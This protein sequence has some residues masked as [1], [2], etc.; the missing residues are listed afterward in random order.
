[1]VTE[2]GS[3]KLKTIH[4]YDAPVDLIN[5]LEIPMPDGADV[6]CVQ[7]QRDE[8]RIWAHIDLSRR[9]DVMRRFRWVGTGWN[10][11]VGRYVG[12]VQQAG[13]VWHLFEVTA[14]EG[15]DR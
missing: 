14:N 4:K 15:S 3:G 9:P 2:E 11:V 10:D 13:Y 7:F 6:L 1:V 5:T 8:P 12:T